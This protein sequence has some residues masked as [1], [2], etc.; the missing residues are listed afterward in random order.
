MSSINIA[1]D[2]SGSISLTV[3][4]V[5]GTNTATLPAATGTVMVSGNMPAFSAYMTNGS[6]NQ[7]TTSGVVTK[8]KIDTKEFD[9]N[10]AYDATTNY[11]F[12]PLVA[13][14]YQVNGQLKAAGSSITFANIY[15]YKNG[16]LWHEGTAF[17]FT[18]TAQ[19]NC[20]VNSLMYLN[21]STD[22]IELWG[23]VNAGSGCGFAFGQSPTY[24]GA[25]LVRVA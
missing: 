14:Y 22:Y 8:V 1:G 3:P 16:S 7:F 13:G 4:S 24:F 18:Q 23:V 20:S 10:S 12:T 5:A 21:G 9:T 2:T 6:A 19:S 17:G 11:R 25:V 15:I